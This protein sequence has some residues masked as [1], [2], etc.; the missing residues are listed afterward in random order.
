MRT[1][2]ILFGVLLAAAASATTYKWVDSKGVTHYSDRPQPGAQI[3]ELQ[4]AQTFDAPTVPS[5]QRPS[6]RNSQQASQTVQYDLD[7]WK[8]E[9]DETFQNTGNVVP[10]R[11]RL[12][13]E[14]QDGHAI[15]I[16]L[17][18]KRVDGLPA[19]GTNFDLPAVP[20]GTHTLTV[21]VADV[22][23]ASIVSSSPVKFHLH[24]PSLLAPNRVRPTPR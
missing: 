5:A 13:P 11:L 12:E 21:V 3:V 17:D 10:V 16:Y 1:A 24:Q 18:G 20:R 15:W 19:S 23:G 4:E 9:N 7:L 6:A 22:S 2:L 8:P 14:L